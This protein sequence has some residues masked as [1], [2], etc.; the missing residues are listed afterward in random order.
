V[1]TLTAGLHII[2]ASYAG[3]SSYNAATSAP[4][5]QTVNKGSPVLP[6]PVVSSPT[7]PYGG[8]ETISETVPPGVTGPVTF[9]DG[10]TVIGTAPIVNGVATIT[11]T[12]LPIGSD[13]ITA[14]TPGDANNNPATSPAT[15]VTVT[16]VTPVL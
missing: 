1:P 7:I 6:G 4:L 15:T 2:T 9:T 10:G 13:P 12:T 16:K 14:S 8:S 5:T 11:V 3:D